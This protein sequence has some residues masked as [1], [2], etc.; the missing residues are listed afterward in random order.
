M[1]KIFVFWVLGAVLNSLPLDAGEPASF[2][3]LKMYKIE[4]RPRE[5]FDASGVI[6]I[7]AALKKVYALK[8]DFLL[9]NDQTSWIYEGQI[10]GQEIIAKPW[11]DLSKFHQLKRFDIEDIDTDGIRLFAV[12]EPDGSL[13]EI[14]KNSKS[15]KFEVK[16]HQ[17]HNPHEE[18]PLSN[19]FGIEGIGTSEGFVYMAKEMSPLGV[20]KYD[21]RLPSSQ[22]VGVKRRE[23]KGSQTSLRIRSDKA[24]VLDRENRCVWEENLMGNPAPKKLSFRSIIE[25]ADL[26]YIVRDGETLKPEWSTAEGLDIV[27]DTFYITLDNNGD[28]LKSKPAETRSSLFVLRRK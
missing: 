16:L 23:S 24:F 8:G 28:G 3:L 5:R 9:V 7:S 4:V 12:N 25:R 26:D 6:A 11:L 27:G 19:Y 10:K 20:F 21:L 15:K 22:Y 13:F 1:R 18:L 14:S 2:D 17:W